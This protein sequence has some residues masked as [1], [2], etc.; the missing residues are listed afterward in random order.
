MVMEAKSWAPA[1]IRLQKFFGG[2]SNIVLRNNLI[3]SGGTNLVLA[4]DFSTA[5]VLLQG[6]NFFA[7]SGA[8]AVSWAGA[9]YANLDDWRAATGQERL[10][11]SV[12]GSSAD[13]RFGRADRAGSPAQR[14]K[15]LTPRRDSPLAGR[16]LRLRSLF[17]VDPGPVDFLGRPL[18]GAGTVGAIQ[19]AT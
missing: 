18:V 13:P 12:V 6:N 9:S 3:V 2:L 19:P 16:A 14:A 10:G 17:D 7:E 1:G 4:D 5:D 11:A 15:A 8:W